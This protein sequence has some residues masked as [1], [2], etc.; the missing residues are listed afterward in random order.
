MQKSGLDGLQTLLFG[1]MVLGC[2]GITCSHHEL[3]EVLKEIYRTSSW[4]QIQ[5]LF[6]SGGFLA[7]LKHIPSLKMFTLKQEHYAT[8]TI[9]RAIG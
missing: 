6:P 2:H 1:L 8:T 9:F 3:V 5:T 7:P 4:D